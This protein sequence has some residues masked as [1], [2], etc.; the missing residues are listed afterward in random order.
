MTIFTAQNFYNMKYPK[1]LL[2]ILAMAFITVSCHKDPPK[3]Y[4]D[5]DMTVTYYNVD[6]SFSTYNTFVMPD[7]VVLTTNYLTESQINNIYKSGGTSDKA[8][9]H[10]RDRFVG[11]GYTQVDSITDANFIAVPTLMMMQQDETIWYGTG[12]WWGYPSY[13]WGWGYYKSTNY[14]YGWYPT[15]P[16]YPTGV[17]VTVSTYNGTI[18]YEMV[19]VASYLAIIEWNENNPEPGPGDVSP[20]LEINWQA[21][22]DGYATD[23]GTYNQERALRGTDEAFAQSPY[24]QK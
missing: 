16:W 14:Y 13:G 22:I 4:D 15:Y 23:D 17:P 12:W 6:F 2:L 20:V 11:L 5:T 21:T 10:L 24:L 18:A 8:L 7:S 1:Y 9:D 3:T 19:D